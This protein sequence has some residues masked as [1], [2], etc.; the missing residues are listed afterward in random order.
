MLEAAMEQRV[1][2]VAR[3][4]AAT[5]RRV[6]ARD[7]PALEPGRNR[8]GHGRA[9]TSLRTPIARPRADTGGTPR[10]RSRPGGTA[11]PVKGTV[12]PDRLDHPGSGRHCQSGQAREPPIRLSCVRGRVA[13][14]DGNGLRTVGRPSVAG[15]TRVPARRSRSC[16]GIARSIESGR[17]SRQQVGDRGKV[18][19][20]R[21]DLESKGTFRP[22]DRST[23][24]PGTDA[25]GTLRRSPIV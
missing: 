15:T 22:L 11:N 9:K 16:W 20:R 24:P 25:A 13:R 7:E 5:M 2:V 8:A 4:P 12:P 23:R 14:R 18:V 21:S 6:P 19:S 3:S 10:L 1:E 17:A